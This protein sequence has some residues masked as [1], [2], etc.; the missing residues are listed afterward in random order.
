[1]PEN[2][3]QT[4]TTLNEPGLLGFDPGR[5]DPHWRVPIPPDE[6]GRTCQGGCQHRRTIVGQIVSTFYYLK[7]VFGYPVGASSTLY[8]DIISW[9]R[10]PVPTRDLPDPGLGVDH[11]PATDTGPP[12]EANITPT[13]PAYPITPSN[14]HSTSPLPKRD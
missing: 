5:P 3:D 8:P 6:D 9:P 10:T 1:M 14:I 4:P 7:K 12:I 2:W 11:E 13:Q